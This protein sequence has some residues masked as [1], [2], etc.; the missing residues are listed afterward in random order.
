MTDGKLKAVCIYR[1]L[2]GENHWI[3]KKQIPAKRLFLVR[4]WAGQSFLRIERSG[5]SRYPRA[6][7]K[8]G[9]GGMIV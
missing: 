7:G 8:K 5:R 3:C 2:G 6:E 4:L 1:G 9:T